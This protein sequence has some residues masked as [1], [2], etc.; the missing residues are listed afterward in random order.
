MRIFPS[1]VQDKILQT[2]ASSSP[3]KQ[4]FVTDLP[5]G[6]ESVKISVINK[7]GGYT[8]TSKDKTVKFSISASLNDDF[9]YETFEQVLGFP[10]APVLSDDYDAY[11][12]AVSDF[13]NT[14][15]VIAK[16]AKLEYTFDLG[17]NFVRK[18]V[19]SEENQMN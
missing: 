2:L 1:N 16:I 7:N 9:L 10:G 6:F 5:D 13:L 18:D 12:K 4:T 15:E 11:E 19:D 8:I 14:P 17:D 3:Y